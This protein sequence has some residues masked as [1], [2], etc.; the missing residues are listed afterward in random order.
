MSQIQNVGGDLK[1]ATKDLPCPE[2]EHIFH[3]IKMFLSYFFITVSSPPR[4][5]PLKLSL[6]QVS[7]KQLFLK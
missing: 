4:L 6:G 5:S 7:C 1:D 3:I 2:H